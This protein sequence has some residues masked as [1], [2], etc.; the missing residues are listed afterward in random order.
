MTMYVNLLFLVTSY[1]RQAAATPTTLTHLLGWLILSFRWKIRQ[2]QTIQRY[3]AK[4]ATIFL[5]LHF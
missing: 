4:F 1:F 5:L 2:N 3:G